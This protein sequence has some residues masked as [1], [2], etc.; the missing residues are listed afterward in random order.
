MYKQGFDFLKSMAPDKSNFAVARE[1]GF[2]G[3]FEVVYFSEH[4]QETRTNKIK[5]HFYKD[6]GFIARRYI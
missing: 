4:Y 2:T 3:E 6:F 5:K 1:N